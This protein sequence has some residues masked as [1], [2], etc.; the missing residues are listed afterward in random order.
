[1]VQCVFELLRGLSRDAMKFE[2]CVAE[3]YVVDNA[4]GLDF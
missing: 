4:R 2:L 1:M 3:Q